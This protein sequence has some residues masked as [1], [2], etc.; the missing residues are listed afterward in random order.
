MTSGYPRNPVSKPGLDDTVIKLWE[1]RIQIVLVNQEVGVRAEE[2]KE[3]TLGRALA[4]R[5]KKRQTHSR[6]RWG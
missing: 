1:G 6:W 5:E 2:A 3:N 4:G